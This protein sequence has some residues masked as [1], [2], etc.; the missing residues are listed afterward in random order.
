MQQGFFSISSEVV[1]NRDNW[2]WNILF[3]GG[4]F[5]GIVSNIDPSGL[6]LTPIMHNWINV[7]ALFSTA[8]GKLGNS[9]LKGAPTSI[10]TTTTVAPDSQTGGK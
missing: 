10:T 1:M 4:L 5:C 2:L 7:F 8:A 9:P 6:G 3:F